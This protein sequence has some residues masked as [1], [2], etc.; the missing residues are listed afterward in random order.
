VELNAAASMDA[1]PELRQTLTDYYG[2]DP[3]GA[4]TAYYLDPDHSL[5]YLERQMAT[6]KIGAA[7]RRQS[8]G[9]GL[10]LADSLRQRGITDAQAEQGFAQV[11]ALSRLQAGDEST[12]GQG[13]LIEGAFGNAQAARRVEQAQQGRRARF[14]GGGGA[15]ES[16]TGVS[17]LGR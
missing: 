1:P 9:V 15:V 7:A 4:L 12:V 5:A 11:S 2:L 14:G 13:D 8:L 10:D 6:A 17:G 16:Q 3:Q